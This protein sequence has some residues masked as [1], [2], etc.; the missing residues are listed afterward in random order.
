MRR[1]EIESLYTQYGAALVAY[2]SALM[3]NRS[4]A[5]DLV[6]HVFLNLLRAGAAVPENPRAYL[7]RAMR[8]A[9][10]NSKRSIAR[11][12]VLD[13]EQAWLV[14]P[15]ESVANALALQASL[16]ALPAEQRE[17]VVMH[18]WGEMTFEEI[19]AVV[20]VPQNTAAS[21]YRY[22]LAK[23]RERLE[24]HPLEKHATEK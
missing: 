10:L 6:Q 21:R 16:L 3:A 5:E 15:G 17:V 7:Y 1:D 23:L 24:P 11:E 18:I 14:A 4:A 20:G 22:G 12:A 19:A 2:G 8:N 13:R 9:A